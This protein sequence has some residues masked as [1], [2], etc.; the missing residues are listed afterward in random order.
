MGT[1][2]TTQTSQSTNSNSS[3]KQGMDLPD[4]TRIPA[5]DL[6]AAEKLRSEGWREIEILETYEGAFSATEEDDLGASHDVRPEDVEKV[7]RL[8][9]EAF[10]HDR[11]HVD[12]LVSARAA[13]EFKSNWVRAACREGGKRRCFV[14]LDQREDVDAF[15]ICFKIGRKLVIDLIAVREEARGYGLSKILIQEAVYRMGTEELR[16]G[17][18][19][20]NA[21]AKALYEGLGMKI[22]QR[23]RTF[24]R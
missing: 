16:A 10:I 23:E 22:V 8:A 5:D 18:Q 1:N 13:G 19:S 2:P 24:H 21:A 7:A 15:L 4:W 6:R 11:H 12:P 17:T 9:G 14:I 20:T 3:A